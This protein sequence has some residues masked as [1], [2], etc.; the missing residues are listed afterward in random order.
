MSH[1]IGLPAASQELDHIEKSFAKLTY[2]LD[3]DK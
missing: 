2:D 1:V 3:W